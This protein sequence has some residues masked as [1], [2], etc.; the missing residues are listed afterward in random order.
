VL[1]KWDYRFLGLAKHVSS[2][3]KDPSTQV[4][5]VI[6]KGKVDLAFG[7]NGLPSTIED[8]LNLYHDR[9]K[10]YKLITHAEINA[11]FKAS[12]KGHDTRGSTVYTYPLGVCPSCASILSAA[13]VARVVSLIDMSVS[14][15]KKYH[16]LSETEYILNMN[17]ILYQWEYVD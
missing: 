6:A 2:F 16:D 14:R 11:L 13:G 12:A 17:G 8:D 10:K 7:Y 1:S 4:G 9:E 15:T 5:A 3:S